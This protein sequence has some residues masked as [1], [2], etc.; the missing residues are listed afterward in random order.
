MME[1]RLGRVEKKI[2]T[3]QEAIVSLARVEERISSVF[4]RQAHIEAKVD[5]IDKKVG[6]LS[7]EVASSKVIER[8]VWLVIAA[9]ITVSFTLI[10]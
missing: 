6:A 1:D 4:E 5:D 7:N 10:G 2:D 8:L 3:L 9:A